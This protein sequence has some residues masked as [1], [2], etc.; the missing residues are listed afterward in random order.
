MIYRHAN[1]NRRGLSEEG[2]FE[3]SI[4]SQSNINIDEN[5]VTDNNIVAYNRKSINF[6]LQDGMSTDLLELVDN[7]AILKMYQ[8]MNSISDTGLNR[9]LKLLKFWNPHSVFPNNA[10]CL[11]TLI[12]K[13]ICNF[14]KYFS[15]Y[16]LCNICFKSVVQNQKQCFNCNIM[17]PSLNKFR[18]NQLIYID[19]IPQIEIILQN[20]LNNIISYH[21]DLLLNPGSDVLSST[22]TD[23]FFLQSTNPLHLHLLLSADG[24]SF[25]STKCDSIWP[26]QAI[27]LDLPPYIRER[28]E[29]MLLVALWASS[30]KPPW[31]I[32]LQKFC[33]T[34]SGMPQIE[35]L[36]ND[37]KIT[38]FIHVHLCICD[39]PALASILNI[40]QYNGVFGC[41]ICMHPGEIF[42]HGK[43]H[44]RIYISDNEYPN[45]TMVYQIAI[46]AA[47]ATGQKFF[48]FNGF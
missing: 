3:S 45:K 40:T 41:P 39:L 11:E 43:G 14:K 26:L 18:S 42:K 38:Y 4:D 2:S 32:F 5:A 29:N 31:E 23:K 34:L 22:A 48:G 33:S 44:S 7:A 1:E 25:Y 8:I 16:F 30:R 36:V 21:K 37:I 20:Q 6:I 13:N 35:V 46:T 17:D 15:T 9:L 12:I 27:I 47:E 10:N 28:M 24:G 19:F